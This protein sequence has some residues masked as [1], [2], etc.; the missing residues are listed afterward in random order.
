MS[1]EASANK[2]AINIVKRYGLD[3]LESLLEHFKANTP[4]PTIA[5]EFGVTR[6]RVN[7]WKKKLGVEYTTFVVDSSVEEVVNT[8][9]ENKKALFSRVKV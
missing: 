1:K 8:Y 5:E 9:S 6:Q 3:K 4:G 2:V 7:Q